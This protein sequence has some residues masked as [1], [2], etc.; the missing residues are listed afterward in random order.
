MRWAEKPRLAKHNLDL[1]PLLHRNGSRGATCAWRELVKGGHLLQHRQAPVHHQRPGQR[2]GSFIADLIF[3]QAA[4]KKKKKNHVFFRGR[5][6]F[7]RRLYSGWVNRGKPCGVFG[8]RYNHTK[9]WML[10]D[11]LSWAGHQAGDCKDSVQ[12]EFLDLKF[13]CVVKRELRWLHGGFHAQ[14]QRAG[15][16]GKWGPI[17]LG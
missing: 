10:Q 3:C 5:K 1:A 12:G 8:L 4:Q 2:F 15:R 6:R 9:W 16:W 11:L 7:S 14:P 17:C 13:I